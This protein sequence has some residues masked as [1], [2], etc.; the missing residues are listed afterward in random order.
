MA[1][2]AKQAG[3][4][5]FLF[6]SSCSIYGKGEKLDLTE[7]DSTNPVSAYAE[8]KIDAEK[9]IGKLADDDFTVGF[10]RN[11][12]AYGYSP[13]LRIDLVVNNLLGVRWRAA[14]SAL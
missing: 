1:A 14:T 7:E 8:S 4:P 3:V 6:A 9:G 2:L 5:R 12:T 13:M 10:L 11:S